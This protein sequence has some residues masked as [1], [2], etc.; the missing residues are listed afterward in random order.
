MKAVV[1]ARS[2][3][4]ESEMRRVVRAKAAKRKRGTPMRVA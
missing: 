4:V 2:R 1:K 3:Q